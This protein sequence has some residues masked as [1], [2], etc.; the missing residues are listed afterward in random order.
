[1]EPAVFLDRDNTLIANDGDL[2]DP[3]RVH[4][5]DGV[6]KGARELREAGYRLVVITNQG[7][8]ARGAFTEDDVDAVHQRIASL[9]VEQSGG[10]QVID[11]FYYCPYHPEAPLEEY[12][13]EHPWRKPNAG[14]LLQ[15]AQDMNL[16]L[17]QCW[18]VG[19]QAR[20]IQARAAA[21]CRT[22][23]LNTDE[24]LRKQTSPSET[25]DTFIDVVQKILSAPPP[26]PPPKV[27]TTQQLPATEEGASSDSGNAT[28]ELGVLR[29]AVNELTEEIRNQRVRRMEFNG[30]RLAAGLFQ[31]LVLLLALLGLLQVGTPDLFIRWILGATL[32]QLFTIAILIL[33]ARG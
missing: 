23:L 3:D 14:M 9:I 25:A 10:T 30:Y 33:D 6:A 7:G 15:A 24:S 1:M 21:G 29:Q 11:R 2:G 20:D 32:L 5:L 8:V 13:R 4:L 18:M 26:P 31:L 16:D 19:D 22:L 27:K 17:S 12:R 28:S